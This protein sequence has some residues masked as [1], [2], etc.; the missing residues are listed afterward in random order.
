[1]N[2]KSRQCPVECPKEPANEKAKKSLAN[3][4]NIFQGRGGWGALLSGGGVPARRDLPPST[5]EQAVS[6]QPL[7]P[8]Q[9]R[10]GGAQFLLTGKRSEDTVQE[11]WH[12]M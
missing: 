5:V 2:G 12:T 1:M 10:S 6:L 4:E 3:R 8:F 11:Q 9:S 7:A